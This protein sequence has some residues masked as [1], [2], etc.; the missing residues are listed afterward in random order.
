MLLSD[1]ESDWEDVSEETVE[2][3]PSA[4][5]RLGRFLAFEHATM[6]TFLD[7]NIVRGAIS[8][9][10]RRREGTPVIRVRHS[11][12]TAAALFVQAASALLFLGTRS[13]PLDLSDFE[14]ARVEMWNG[15]PHLRAIP[16]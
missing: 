6:P 16:R 9:R 4:R 11:R 1:S 7:L 12:E 5:E 13:F 8:L 3:S 14:D 15:A 10:F 2:D